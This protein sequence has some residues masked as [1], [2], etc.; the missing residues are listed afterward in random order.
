MTSSKQAC[1]TGAEGE[2]G[3]SQEYV[4]FITHWWQA[5]TLLSLVKLG[6]L[7]PTI[8]GIMV[9][10][11]GIIIKAGLHRCTGG[12][13]LHKVAV[14][15]MTRSPTRTMFVVIAVLTVH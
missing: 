12:V 10:V 5:G 3:R 14:V 6:A 15:M 9:L 11:S 4:H 2:G 7:F 8:L 1:T 13:A